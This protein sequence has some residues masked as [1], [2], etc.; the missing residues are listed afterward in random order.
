[1]FP[2]QNDQFGA[3]RDPNG[4]SFL[5]GGN[6]GPPEAD[7]MF[8]SFFDG[9]VDETEVSLEPTRS[10]RENEVLAVGLHFFEKMRGLR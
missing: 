3:P 1:M 6:G 9:E 8:E 2:G 5:G 10:Q 4:G 7:A